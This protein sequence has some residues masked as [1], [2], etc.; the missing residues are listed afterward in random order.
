LLRRLH[1]DLDNLAETLVLAGHPNLKALARPHGD[2]PPACRR[3]T[4]DPLLGGRRRKRRRACPLDRHCVPTCGCA[5]R[6]FDRDA[7]I[8]AKL[9]VSI[10]SWEFVSVLKGAFGASWVAAVERSER[11]L[12]VDLRRT[13]VVPRTAG[14]GASCPLACILAKVRSASRQRA[15]SVA[16]GTGLHASFGTLVDITRTPARAGGG[17][18]FAGASFADAAVLGQRCPSDRRCEPWRAEG[19]RYRHRAEPD[20]ARGDVEPE[21]AAQ[22]VV[23]PATRPGSERHAEG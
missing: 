13:I 1:Q 8:L 4:W 11:P 7:L 10:A 12:W 20:A 2:A 17:P 3:T 16:A 9:R 19:E 14:F 5:K 18:A 22:I 15:F 23:H 21:V 6:L